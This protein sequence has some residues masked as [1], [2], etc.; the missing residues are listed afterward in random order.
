[1]FTKGFIK[2]AYDEKAEYEKADRVADELSKIPRKDTIKAGARIAYHPRERGWKEGPWGSHTKGCTADEGI[3]A[4]REA[5]REAELK[6]HGLP[7]KFKDCKGAKQKDLYREVTR[8][9]YEKFPMHHSGDWKKE[10]VRMGDMGTVV[11]VVK[12]PYRPYRITWDKHPD[13]V[14]GNYGADELKV[15]EGA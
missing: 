2:T 9:E 1:M 15:I 4:K 10:A 6:K 13:C 12:S 11:E 14:W 7:L 3:S 5:W 8:D